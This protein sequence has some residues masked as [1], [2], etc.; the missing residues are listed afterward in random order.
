MGANTGISGACVLGKSL[1]EGFSKEKS[2]NDI[3]RSYERDWIPIGRKSVLESRAAG[4]GDENEDLSG[5]RLEEQRGAA[6]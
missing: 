3:P 4:E 2:I 5:G 6:V 1:L